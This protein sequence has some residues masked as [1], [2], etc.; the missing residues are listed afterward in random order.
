MFLHCTGCFMYAFWSPKNTKNSDIF[1]D[2]QFPTDEC[3]KKKFQGK[4]G[5]LVTLPYLQTEI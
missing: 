4:I 1:I 5:W 3:E 2:Y